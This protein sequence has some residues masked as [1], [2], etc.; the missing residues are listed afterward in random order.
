[1][2]F[3]SRKN[4]KAQ[5]DDDSKLQAELEKEII[6]HNMPSQQTIS[7]EIVN[8]KSAGSVSLDQGVLKSAKDFKLMGAI[9]LFVGMIFIGLI[10]FLS[11]KYVISPTAKESGSSTQIEEVDKP[12]VKE[13]VKELEPESEAEEVPLEDQGAIITEEEKPVLQESEEEQDLM[14]EEFSGVD[15]EDLP[16]LLDSDGDGLYDEEELI[17][18]TSIVL[19]DSD[20]DGH[21]DLIEI[22]NAYN[23]IG[24][25]LLAEAESISTYTKQGNNFSFIHPSAWELNEVNDKLFTLNINEGSLIQLVLMDNYD[26]L[27]VLN[28]FQDNFP[29]EEISQD[30]FISKDSYEGVVSKDG[31]NVY[32]SNGDRKTIYVF[33]YI[34]AAPER[35]GF[36]NIFNMIY[37]SFKLGS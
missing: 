26:N 29:G 21:E 18:G 24:E 33:S 15:L 19:K 8:P 23:P 37:S 6:V 13:K 35:L 2:N 34:P 20:D 32:L 30:K 22:I 16:P 17:L 4:K 11:Y 36:I 25:G 12:V 5:K 27:S 28:W 14:Q 9:I 31:L 1:M 7:G 3:F 10:V